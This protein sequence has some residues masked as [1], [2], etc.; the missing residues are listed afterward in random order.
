MSW[1]ED[2]LQPYTITTGDGRQYT[3]LWRNP[4]QAQEYNVAEFEFPGVR[5][6]LV[7]RGQPKGRTFPIELYFQ[8]DDHL[9]LSEAFRTSAADRRAWRVQ[10]PYYGTLV[11]HPASLNFDNSG[12]NVTKI[13]GS[14]LE[15]IST[16][17]PKSTTAPKEQ[18]QLDVATVQTNLAGAYGNNAT[19][20]ATDVQQ[21]QQQ[22]AVSQARGS[23]L[24]DADSTQAYFN[25]FNTA[26]G[27]IVGA[28]QQPLE[29][30][31]KIQAV[32][33]APAL[34]RASVQ[35]RIAL[36]R[37]N[38]NNLTATL[39]GLTLN[40]KHNIQAQ[41]GTLVSAMA[42][43][44]VNPLA[45]D[46]ANKTDVL[47]TV[48]S[49]LSAYNAYLAALDVLQSINGGSPTSFVPDALAITG[50]SSLVN[51]ALSNLLEIAV[52]ARQE[53]SF[54][55]EDDSNWI[56]LTHR[57]YGGQGDAFDENLLRLIADNKAGLN[58][59]LRVLKGRVIVYYV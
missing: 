24:A 58:E 1:L 12:Y 16:V 44:A 7:V 36:L 51:F 53:Y 6:T 41:G 26:N 27:A 23:L 20:T 22:L 35:S 5:G 33:A 28:T 8:G 25:A 48:G 50:L 42:L 2:T 56:I 46:Y 37:D 21:L 32:I 39:A 3:P 18:V 4:Q 57:L 38:L 31:R 19:P 55:L 11:V 17:Y 49:V 47:A 52:D 29:A 10:H 14:L 40:Q 45:G 9:Q 15:T 54:I 59:M 13:T 43:A 34:F 30:M